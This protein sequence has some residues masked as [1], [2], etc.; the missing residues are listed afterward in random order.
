MGFTHRFFLCLF[1][2]A[3]KTRKPASGKKQV[4]LYGVSLVLFSFYM[5][6]E[7]S[8]SAPAALATSEPS[9]YS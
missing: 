7:K 9:L 6:N 3:L 5:S 2:T 8:S 1:Q 4:F